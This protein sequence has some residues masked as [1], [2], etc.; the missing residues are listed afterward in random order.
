[1]E[2]N[3]ECMRTMILQMDSIKNAYFKAESNKQLPYK[4]GLMMFYFLGKVM[5]KVVPLLQ[6]LTKRI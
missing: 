5:V 4:N 6:E 2:M 1:M 3:Q